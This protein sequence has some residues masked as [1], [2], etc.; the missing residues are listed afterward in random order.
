MSALARTTEIDVILSEMPAWGS[1]FTRTFANHAPMVLCALAEIGGTP[2]Q[3]RRFFD[4]YRAYKNLLPFGEPT[5]PLDATTWASALGERNR[6]PDFRVFFSGEVARLGIDGTLRHYLPVLAPGVAASAFH[7]LMRTAYGV[8]RRNETDIAIALGYW[9]ATYLALPP[10]S[11][12]PPL[13]D[14]PAEVLLRVTQIPAMHELPLHDLLWQNIRDAVALPDFVPVV[15]WLAIGPQTMARMADVA[16]RLF[17]ATQHFAALHVVTGLHWIRLIAPY[18]DAD[19]KDMLLRVFWQAI[20]ALI[21]ELDFPELP[22][23]E[24]VARWRERPA[25][26]WPEIHAAAAASFDEHDISLAYSASEDM[27]IYGDPLYRVAAARRLG[28]IGDYRI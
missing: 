19:T 23:E 20:A 17:A 6:E 14:D 26:D 24:A 22:S 11:G 3:M 18:C 12:A 28:L 7:A 21:R 10:A 1:E 15:D 8:L 2:A 16:I 25:P 9:A 5:S 27:K 13:T 4:H